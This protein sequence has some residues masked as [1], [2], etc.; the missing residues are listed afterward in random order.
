M[1]H[2][3]TK[4]LVVQ[5][6]YRGWVLDGVWKLPTGFIQEKKY[7]QEPS[8][9]STKKQGARGLQQAEPAK[10]Q[11]SLYQIMLWL[12][13]HKVVDVAHFLLFVEGKAV[14]PTVAG[15]LESIPGVKVVYRTKE[16][17]EQQARRSEPL[18]AEFLHSFSMPIH[19][20]LIF[21]FS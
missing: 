4:V 12:Y 18:F 20:L 1:G 3:G 16:L 21:K 10:L 19:F 14:K 5:E 2:G 11:R 7:T 9:R 17:E 6:K 8:E 13:Y 15:V